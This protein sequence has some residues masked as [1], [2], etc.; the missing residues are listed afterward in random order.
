MN[1]AGSNLSFDER[2]CRFEF[3]P[4]YADAVKT[5]EIMKRAG[6]EVLVSSGMHQDGW[7]LFPSDVS[8]HYC[9]MR[10]DYIPDLVKE[11]CKKDIML[12]SWYNTNQH[13]GLGEKHPDWRRVMMK[14]DKEEIDTNGHM[15]VLSSPYRDFVLRYSKEILDMGFNGMWYDGAEGGSR[16][17]LSCYC[18]YCEEAFEKEF[19]EK[20]PRRI[21][22]DSDLFCEWIR[23]RYRRF[24]EFATRLYEGLI[25]HK[26]DAVIMMN[27]LN[28]PTISNLEDKGIS[29]HNA[30]SIDVMKFGGGGGN[31]NSS[32]MN[33]LHSTGF[34]ARIVK[35]QCPE[36]FDIWEPGGTLWRSVVYPRL[37][38]DKTHS[39]LH[40]VWT[41]AL[42]G[43]PWTAMINTLCTCGKPDAAVMNEFK[44]RRPYIGGKALTY[45]AVHYSQSS[46]DFL[47]RDNP[48]NYYM[49]VYGLYT[50]AVEGHYLTDLILDSHLED[51]DYLM[52][53]RVII[54]P[55]S[56]C[57]NEKQMA[58]LRQYVKA[59]GVLISSFETSL[60]NE[61]G[62]KRLDFGLSDLFGVH[63]TETVNLKPGDWGK[64]IYDRDNVSYET[65]LLR[66]NDAYFKKH[67]ASYV[68][69]GANYVK[70]QASQGGGTKV[71]ADNVF[72]SADNPQ[73]AYYSL[74]SPVDEAEEY[75]KDSPAVV[76]RKYGKGYSVYFCCEAGRGFWQWPHPEAR[77]LIEQMI[78]LGENPINVKAPKIVEVSAFEKGEKTLAIHLVNLPFASNRPP[79][80]GIGIQVVDEIVPIHNIEV[81]IKNVKAKKVSLPLS[82]EKLGVRYSG[83]ELIITVPCLAYHEVIWIE[84]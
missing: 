35:A 53:Y 55:N 1:K 6:V 42:G 72:F 54:L 83:K 51:I 36:R 52:R 23:W 62:R 81:R 70:S 74:Y 44:K 43:V 16:R 58:A 63:Y 80:P 40:G 60:Y 45:C 65:P 49:E 34:N 17:D 79:I 31:E 38:N 10:K 41:L 76:V 27:H 57:L 32:V 46:R 78:E 11:A 82:K 12:L 18:R 37:E 20:Q 39:I 15:C 26:P 21:D 4:P 61:R 8:P 69:F 13:K 50:V 7:S 47:G 73:D 2:V 19:G 56:G 25:E 22:W 64:T 29:W 66:I 67:I 77:K 68:L 48:V 59:G 84:K 3:R 71:F 9:E 24:D 75:S 33:R 14:G 30:V 5:I 28:R